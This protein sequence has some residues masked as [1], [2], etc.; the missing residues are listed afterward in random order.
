[1]KRIQWVVLALLV[2]GLGG[3]AQFMSLFGINEDGTV[4]PGGGVLGTVATLVN[5]WIPGTAALVGT[6]TTAMAALRAKKWKKAF[7]TSAKVLEEGEAVGK[8]I[9]EIKPDLFVAH[10][11][12][13]VGVMVEKALDKFVRTDPA[14][15][16][17][18][19]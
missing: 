9:E 3:C 1:M 2:L 15:T 14:P 8:T 18:A 5:L 10:T 4:T 16:P 19:S 6:A 17:P 12:A 7:V 11:L 13:G